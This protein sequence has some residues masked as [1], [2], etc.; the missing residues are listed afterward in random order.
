MVEM[1]CIV[2]PMGC[3]LNVDVENNY[4]VTGNKCSRG[5]IYGKEE[6]IAPKRVVTSTVK[7]VGGIHHRISVKTDRAIAKEKVYE[8]MELLNKIEVKSPIK[9][10]D[11]ILENIL[12][13]DVNIVAT[14]DM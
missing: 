4:E 12:G 2:C 7:I 1:I 11:K 13:T 3:H 6:L 9:T 10:G 14:R 8:C 5:A